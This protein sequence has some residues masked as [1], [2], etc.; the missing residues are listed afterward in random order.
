M[1]SFSSDENSFGLLAENVFA[2]ISGF[3][4][5]AEI[6][7]NWSQFY[8]LENVSA[9]P[10]QNGFKSNIAVERFT[11]ISLIAK[12]STASA[13]AL[14]ILWLVQAYCIICLGRIFITHQVDRVT[15]FADFYCGFRLFNGILIRLFSGFLRILFTPLIILFADSYV[16][17]YCEI[18]FKTLLLIITIVLLKSATHLWFEGG[19]L[20]LL[21]VL[22]IGLCQLCSELL[23]QSWIVRQHLVNRQVRFFFHKCGRATPVFCYYYITYKI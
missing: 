15:F 3:S 4:G 22:E 21:D 10:P 8:L 2:R 11:I 1:K 14:I 16:V 7:F 23:S 17:I 18:R 13:T 9:Y 5:R 12:E 6:Y 19:H 20:L